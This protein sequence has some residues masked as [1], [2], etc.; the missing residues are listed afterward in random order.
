V[1]IDVASAALERGDDETDPEKMFDRLWMKE[2]LRRAV[3]KV[4]AKCQATKR[5]VPFLVFQRYD[6]DVSDRP[7]YGDIAK[8]LGIKESDV[9]NHLHEIR[10]K[11]RDEVKAEISADEG[12][13]D[14]SPELSK[15][16]RA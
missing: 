12:E 2:V 9:R 3:E 14:V 5:V 15:L 6:L 8:E 11:V 16:F 13:S 7:S 4:R 10:E 1:S